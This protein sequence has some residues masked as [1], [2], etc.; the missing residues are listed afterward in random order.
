MKYYKISEED[1]KYFIECRAKLE[2]L[3]AWGV[4]NWT[5]YDDANSDYLNDMK[6]MYEIEQEEDLDFND[7]ANHEIKKFQEV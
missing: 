6:A 4:D 1:L 7:I 5:W 2:A 3:E